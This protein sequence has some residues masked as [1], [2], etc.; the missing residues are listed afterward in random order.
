VQFLNMSKDQ[1]QSQIV[2]GRSK[3]ADRCSISERDIVGHRSTYLETKPEVGGRMGRPAGWAE[4]CSC[5]R[6]GLMLE[7]PVVAA[8]CQVQP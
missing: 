1:I 4:S 2:G 6:L 8:I 5:R 3:I 7:Q